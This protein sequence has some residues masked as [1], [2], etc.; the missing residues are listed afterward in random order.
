MH[1]PW[2]C[3]KLVIAIFNKSVVIF[4]KPLR[5]RPLQSLSCCCI[6]QRKTRGNRS[7]AIVHA[8]ELGMHA[9]PLIM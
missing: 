7:D 9:A 6:R 5:C 1:T 2:R 3:F 4:Y 8:V